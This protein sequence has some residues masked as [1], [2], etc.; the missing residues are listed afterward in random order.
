MPMLYGK[1]ITF[2]QLTRI[3]SKMLILVFNIYGKGRTS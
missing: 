1:L 3:T 2:M